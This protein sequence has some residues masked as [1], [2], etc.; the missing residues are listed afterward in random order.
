[1]NILNF[2]SPSVIANIIGIMVAVFLANCQVTTITVSDEVLSP[3]LL[4]RKR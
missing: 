2:I 4:A 1:M 3:I